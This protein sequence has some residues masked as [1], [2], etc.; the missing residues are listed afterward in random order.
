MP[1]RLLPAAA[2]PDTLARRGVLLSAPA[3]LLAGCGL[4]PSDKEDEAP[5]GA[6]DGAEGAEGTGGDGAS[7]APDPAT[8]ATV[9]LTAVE[10]TDEV[11]AGGLMTRLEDSET[12]LHPYAQ[13][14]VTATALLDSLTADQYTALTG[15]EAPLPDGADLSGEESPATTLLP[16]KLKKF[17]LTAWE[18][19]DPGWTPDPS[20]ASTELH[21]T[22]GGNEEIRVDSTRKGDA[23]RSGIV[24][25]VVDATPEAAAVAVRA[26]TGDGAQEI[27]LIDGTIL[28]T[29]APRMYERGLEVQIS[30]A[31]ALETQIPDGF[32]QDVI[33]L[34]GTVEEA[35]LSPFVAASVGHGGDLGWAQEDEI[36]LVVPLSWESDYSANVEDRTEVRLLL[37]DGTELHPAQSQATMFSNSHADTV[38]TFTIPAALDTA[39]LEI[40]P[41]FGQG[42][43]QEFEQVEETLTA[44]LTFA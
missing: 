24:L 35:Y 6:A 21:L 33:T 39:T 14:T 4:L 37:P 22:V 28:T 9:D 15:E 17:L 18:S 36:H 12:L 7:S 25:A 34:R 40:M 38:A 1:R 10:V 13:V 41:R 23:E 20:N 8:S 19:T 31:G 5:Q 32:G 3:L 44:K 27:S 16:G 29:P 30:E 11:I 42:L 26:T 43:D 2:R